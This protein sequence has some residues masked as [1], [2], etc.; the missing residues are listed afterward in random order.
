[1]RKEVKAIAAILLLGVVAFMMGSCQKGKV[2]SVSPSKK[3]LEVGDKSSLTCT[4]SYGNEVEW[5]KSSNN[6]IFIPSRKEDEIGIRATKEGNC[7]VIASGRKETSDVCDIE[8]KTYIRPKQTIEL[9][10]GDTATIVTRSGYPLSFGI[11]EFFYAQI[12]QDS[13]SFEIVYDSYQ[14]TYA[15]NGIYNTTY[16]LT[17]KHVGESFA[18][19]Y[20]TNNLDCAIDTGLVVRVLARY[21]NHLGFIDFDDTQDSVRMKVGTNYSEEIT[22]EGDLEWTFYT[23]PNTLLITVIFDQNHN[24]NLVKSFGLVYVDPAII[25]EFI[26]SIEERCEFMGTYQGMNLYSNTDNSTIIGIQMI[27]NY[28]FVV[29]IPNGSKPTIDRVN[30]EIIKN[31]K[32]FR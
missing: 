32:H 23:Y 6:I 13:N 4:Y 29:V 25:A 7:R 17:A 27:D 18:R 1:M 5:T 28:L 9:Y 26:A 20:T 12:V 11:D 15:P 3:V 19:F 24:N 10:V 30:N 8:V 31:I 2:E 16:I 21:P 22:D 14:N